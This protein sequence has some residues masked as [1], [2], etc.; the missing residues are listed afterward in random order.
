MSLEKDTTEIQ[1]V[2]EQGEG[3]FK[4]ADEEE[5]ADRLADA[6]Q[7]RRNLPLWFSLRAVRAG[8]KIQAIAE[9][10]GG[11]FEEEHP[12]CDAIIPA[13]DIKIED[14]AIKEDAG[15]DDEGLQ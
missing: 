14:R 3:I 9:V 8:S 6:E 4:P 5:V 2:F 12:L 7:K 13:R 11:R 15:F 1:K 10:E